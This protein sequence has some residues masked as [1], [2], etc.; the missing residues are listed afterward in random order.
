VAYLEG[1][2]RLIPEELCT[3]HMDEVSLIE[4][5]PGEVRSTQRGIVKTGGKVVVWPR[6]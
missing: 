5:V 1:D 4:L 3:W 6:W 2:A